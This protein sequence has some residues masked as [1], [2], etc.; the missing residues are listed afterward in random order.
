MEQDQL[1]VE[2]ARVEQGRNES[3]VYSVPWKPVD[4]WVGIFLLALIDVAL[5]VAASQGAGAQLAQ[6]AGL[7]LIQLAYLL[8]LIVIFAYRRVNPKA[9]GFGMFEWSTL[10]IGCGLLVASYVII[11]AHNAILMLLGVDT[12][13]DQ[14]LELFAALDSPVWFILVGVIFAPFVEELFFRGFLFQGFRQK[15][16][17]VKGGLLSSVIFGMAHLDP[18]AFIPT[19]ILGVLLAYMYHRSNSVWPGIILHVLINALG[20]CAAYAA[21]QMPGVIPV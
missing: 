3:Q 20:M 13:G 16:G 15:Y 1:S 19:T 2:N 18:V 12:Q 5:L 10:G 14:I 21:T 17:W 8:P 11:L 9:L 7:I 4:H 6:T